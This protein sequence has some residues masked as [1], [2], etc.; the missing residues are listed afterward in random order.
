M[1]AGVPLLVEQTFSFLSEPPPLLLPRAPRLDSLLAA[2]SLWPRAILFDFDGVLV[3]SEPLHFLAFSDALAEEKIPLTEAEYYQELIGFDDRGAFK[4]IFEKNGRTLDPKTFLR[5]MTRKKELMLRQ[6]HSRKYSALPGVEE[7]VRSLWR[8]YPL[9]VCSGALRDE[10]DLMLEGV[11]LRDCFSVVVSAEDVTVGKPDPQCYLLTTQLL[12]EK[13]G[14]RIQPS[15]CLV[16]ED[17][18][19]VA[20]SIRPVGFP[21]L[22]VAT[23]YPLEKLGD[24]NWAVKSLDPDTVQKVLPGLAM[25]R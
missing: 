22:A 16:V 20:R 10:I 18:P 21:V 13:V 12:S 9:A 23:S 25:Y 24:A 3:N 14:K 6:I 17:A 1:M 11:S 19:A 15:D 5:I 4:Y 7:F 2:M 8:H